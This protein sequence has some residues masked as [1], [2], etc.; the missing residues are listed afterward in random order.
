[1]S[2]FAGRQKRTLQNLPNNIVSAIVADKSVADEEKARGAAASV[3]SSPAGAGK[4]QEEAWKGASL[5]LPIDQEKIAF[6]QRQVA[7]GQSVVETLQIAVEIANIIL[8][9]VNTLQSDVKNYYRPLK[10]VAEA[11]LE[12]LKEVMTSIASTGMY[13]LPILPAE[14]EIA[15]VVSKSNSGVPLSVSMRAVSDKLASS[16]RSGNPMSAFYTDFGKAATSKSDP[17]RPIF[18]NAGDYVGG[19]ALFLDSATNAADLIQDIQAFWKLT[20]NLINTDA[21]SVKPPE[22]FKAT[23]VMAP[24][25]GTTL[26][27][28]SDNLLGDITRSLLPGSNNYPAVQLTWKSGPTLPG[29]SGWHL[30][31]L[32][33]AVPDIKTNDEGDPIKDS[34]GK[35]VYDYTDPTFNE[36]KPV[37]L[38]N[39][40]GVANNEHLDFDVVEGTTYYYW[41]VPTFFDKGTKKYIDG[42]KMSASAF[43][44]AINCI[45]DDQAIPVVQTPEGFLP[46]N[47]PED[48]P[49][50]RSVTVRDILGKQ[51][52]LAYKSLYNTIQ[53]LMKSAETS[54]YQQNELLKLLETK[55]EQL[56][57][58]LDQTQEI[59]ADMKSLKFS[60]SA[61]SLM[62]PAKEGG[63]ENFIKRVKSAKVPDDVA[64]DQAPAKQADIYYKAKE[65]RKDLPANADGNRK[66]KVGTCSIY[67]AVVVVF[68]WPGA[69]TF[70]D[71]AKSVADTAKQQ[72]DITNIIP[73]MATGASSG[74]K[75]K[76][77]KIVENAF[78]DQKKWV[79]E[80]V[81][82]L[83]K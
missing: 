75:A 48:P 64:E 20:G 68:G 62:L 12:Q 39:V 74:K 55:L 37:F 10:V 61:M 79:I 15:G 36:G 28:N 8:E 76:A 22:N 78:K 56:A 7:K 4:Q 29:F 66:P 41:L 23:A 17:N 6:L 73:S 14:M 50:W 35:V 3:T 58:V 57:L 52:D 65:I 1:M 54:V 24:K 25:Q 2:T 77:N 53:R 33:Q 81:M 27:F 42:S 80:M 44:T 38:S 51:L 72:A 16:A 69:D 18:N 5:S 49:Y 13:I 43:A 60:G 26:L 71:A 59:L 30:Y 63:M 70:K 11:L 82:G 34:E 47:H 31:R 46:G 9:I 67:A 40:A 83:L 45:P 19:F 21:L 32:T